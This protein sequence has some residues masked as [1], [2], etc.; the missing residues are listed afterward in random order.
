MALFLSE[1]FNHPP[2]T[3]NVPEFP[4]TPIDL[5]NR[6]DDLS[7]TGYRNWSA[8]D[9]E[10]GYLRV[11]MS[12]EDWLKLPEKPKSEWMRGWAYIMAPA[13][14]LHGITQGKMYKL[15]S[16]QLP[17]AFVSI[18]YWLRFKGVTSDL[19]PDVVVTRAPTT[20]Y[21]TQPPIVAI[22]ILSP[23][24]WRYDKGEKADDYAKVGVAQYWLVDYTNRVITVEFNDSGA[25]VTHV[26]LSDFNPEAD[27]VVSDL[28]TVHLDTRVLFG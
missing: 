3:D 6:H 8:E 18:E 10:R 9:L 16:D 4:G 28:G 13:A 7:W 27:I 14:N 21:D 2:A 11:R 15:L 1:S 5:R 17:K 20:K 12:R 26:V 19:V 25:W 22:E 24:N 23:G